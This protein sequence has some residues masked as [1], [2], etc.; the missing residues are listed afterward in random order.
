RYGAGPGRA[1]LGGG[2]FGQAEGTV[3]WGGSGVVKSVTA[4]DVP[5]LLVGS[6]GTLGVIVGATLRLHPVPIATGSWIGSFEAP[7]GADGFLAE[8]LAS[9]LEPER[10][11][12][13]NAAAR[14]RCGRA[15]PGI[16]VLLSIGSAPEAV[17]GQGAALAAMAG[18][19]GGAFDALP[20]SAVSA[21]PPPPAAPALASPVAC[22]LCGEVR[23]IVQWLGRAEALAARAGLELSAVGQAGNGVL[24]LALGGPLPSGETITEG[25]LVPLRQELAGEGGGVTV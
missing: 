9:S 15:G 23:R 12:L 4:Y 14:R 11:V 19:H 20:A 2:G 17:E 25:L 24:H 10:L 6:L 21:R 5:R 8:L 13:Q 18:P 3:T 22:T 7:A 16:A 1:L